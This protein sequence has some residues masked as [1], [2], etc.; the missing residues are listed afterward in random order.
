MVEKVTFG[1]IVHNLPPTN[2]ELEKAIREGL[3]HY[4][5]P[6]AK[7]LKEGLLDPNEITNEHTA[8]GPDARGLGIKDYRMLHHLAAY[9][10][11]DSI[12]NL[13]LDHNADVRVITSEGETPLFYV[14]NV[15]KLNALVD[16]VGD[17]PDTKE[18]YLNQLNY[19]KQN[20]AHAFVLRH[21]GHGSETDVPTLIEAFKNA[22]GNINLRDE[23]GFTPLD[24]AAK[25]GNFKAVKF[26][27]A[28]RKLGAKSS[29]EFNHIEFESEVQNVAA[30][31]RSPRD[32]PAPLLASEVAISSVNSAD[33]GSIP[34]LPLPIGGYRNKNTQ[35]III[36]NGEEVVEKNGDLVF[37]KDN[38]HID[39]TSYVGKAV[40]VKL[41]GSVPV[42]AFNASIGDR[43]TAEAFK[44]TSNAMEI[45]E[46][47]VPPGRYSG[48]D[49]SD[50]FD[51]SPFAVLSRTED[52][53][54][55]NFIFSYSMGSEE[56]DRYIFNADDK[57]ESR[58][59]PIMFS[60]AG[61]E[62]KEGR[63]LQD[64]TFLKHQPRTITVG[65]VTKRE[66]GYEVPEYSDHRPV[67]AA[68]IIPVHGKENEGTSLS[69]PYAAALYSEL[70]ARYGKSDTYPHGLTF[71]EIIYGM[72]RS[73]NK[74]A[75]FNGKSLVFAQN[76]SGLSYSDEVGFGVLDA[77]AA[78]KTCGEMCRMKEGLQLG[79]DEPIAEK[80]SL[81]ST[82]AVSGQPPYA[83]RITAQKAMTLHSFHMEAYIE[84]AKTKEEMSWHRNPYS[85]NE[86]IPSPEITVHYKEQ[87]FRVS[88]S[89]TGKGT[90]HAV[91][92]MELQSGD[93][94]E[95]R[96]ST[97]LKE[98]S[99]LTIR[100]SVPGGIVDIYSKSTALGEQIPATEKPAAH[101]APPPRDK[102]SSEFPEH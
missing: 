15:H 83:Y 55:G 13:Y 26:V 29:S 80:Y 90:I 72:A 62:G 51:I 64:A 87:E 101:R 50:D 17:G 40:A 81:P 88:P 24:Y 48:I 79:R 37:E 97:P 38:K 63:H 42:C 69:S 56:S 18:A 94:I 53:K 19:K 8:S 98:G 21:S 44:A 25:I 52:A 4:Y 92:G 77:L 22:G 47:L 43:T 16:K 82:V 68:P 54:K 6:L 71:D 49:Y 36:E 45:T 76:K 93:I 10:K 30:N 7:A 65:A 75:V 33:V 60:S 89:N 23:D 9:P 20:A 12:F 1:S 31:I 46:E 35:L 5:G 86:P 102:V 57:D 34:T 67:F 59:Y 58:V 32:L 2:D 85:R 14:E 100:G 27:D 95:I 84:G 66:D 74:N 39:I 73:T 11:Q 61:N 28:M 91:R 41:S 70:H 3:F 96:S 78:D 99:D